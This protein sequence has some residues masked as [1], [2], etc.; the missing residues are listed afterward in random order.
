MNYC[1]RHGSTKAEQSAL[2]RRLRIGGFCIRTLLVWVTCCAPAL[3]FPGIGGPVDRFHSLVWEDVTAETIRKALQEGKSLEMRYA[4]AAAAGEFGPDAKELA[5]L[6]TA[7]LEHNEDFTRRIVVSA[8]GNI[9]PAAADAVPLLI[10]ALEDD[11]WQTKASAAEALGRIGQPSKSAISALSAVV[12]RAKPDDGYGSPAEMAATALGQFGAPARDAVP[13]LVAMLTRS[14]L[15]PYARGAAAT[16]LG[17]IAL[18]DDRKV[19]S[20]L[21]KAAQTKFRGISFTNDGWRDEEASVRIAAGHAVWKISRDGRVVS[22]LCEPLKHK[23]YHSYV[24][25]EAAKALGE[26]GPDAADAV[27]MLL[28]MVTDWE[29]NH[30]AEH[31]SHAAV[32][33][34]GRIGK[35]AVDA[36]PVLIRQVEQRSVEWMR[37]AA[38][39]ALGEI[40]LSTKPALTALAEA[41]EGRAY[42]RPA[43]EVKIAAAEAI[44]RLN[45]DV[46]PTIPVLIECLSVKEFETF[47]LTYF[48]GVRDAVAV[49]TR[50]TR[51]LGQLGGRATAAVPALQVLLDDDFITVREAAAHAL[52]MIRRGSRP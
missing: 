11:D 46:E 28:S 25:N 37:I 5:P 45:G 43:Y 52:S 23:D 9:G 29:R 48:P 36:V 3:A 27:P 15:S 21:L 38:A 18:P 39:E 2:R 19:N 35:K 49:R 42:Q 4:A 22:W 1:E 51:A 16:A 12:T 30:D 24:R 44:R 26:I 14:Q 17:K 20:A 10:R 41:L 34:L 8:L 50:A 33:A 47:N 7:A 31:C 13:I 32:V 40:G 6:L